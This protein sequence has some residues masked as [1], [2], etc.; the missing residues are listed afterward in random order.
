MGWVMGGVERKEKTKRKVGAGRR[1]KRK[2][3]ENKGPFTGKMKGEE[4]ADK[5][6]VGCGVRGEENGTEKIRSFL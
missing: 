2:K 4:S 1:D 5:K 6:G 3:R